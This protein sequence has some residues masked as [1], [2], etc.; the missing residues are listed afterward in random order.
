[1]HYLTICSFSFWKI[2]CKLLYLLYDMRVR[3]IDYIFMSTV[4]LKKMV[5]QIHWYKICV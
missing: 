3:I 1:M 5:L 2:P 4:A